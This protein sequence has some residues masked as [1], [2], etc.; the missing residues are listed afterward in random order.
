MKKR[1]FYLKTKQIKEYFSGR[2]QEGFFPCENRKYFYVDCFSASG[3]GRMLEVLDFK[4]ENM[5][6]LIRKLRNF[7]EQNGYTHNIP[8]GAI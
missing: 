2:M 4:E 3:G 5:Q 8:T 6:S 7:A 1:K